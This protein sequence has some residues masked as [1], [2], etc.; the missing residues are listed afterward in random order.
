MTPTA[1][2]FICGLLTSVLPEG[3]GYIVMLKSYS[4]ESRRPAS[5]FLTVAGYVMTESQFK[6]LNEKWRVALDGLPYFHMKEGHHRKY[7]KI[8]A[9]LLD[10]I[11]PD[12]MIAGFHV[13]LHEP[14]HK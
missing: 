2:N 5:P 3:N 9:A 4:D 13:A 14:Y 8:Y 6:A 7:P 12:H 10:L 11:T 1:Y